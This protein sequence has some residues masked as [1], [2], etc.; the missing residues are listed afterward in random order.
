MKNKNTLVI[1]LLSVVVVLAGVATGW[2]ISGK[3]GSS[4]KVGDASVATPEMVSQD[5]VGTASEEADTAEGA[6]ES[7]GIEGEGTHHLVR[8]GGEQQVV[9][10]T[11]TVVDLESFVGKDVQ[12]WGVTIQAQ[13]APWLMDVE[14][15][16]V[17][18]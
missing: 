18:K 13:S 9:Y 1:V 4:V 3:K 7:G 17:L 2:L 8:P 16:K 12:V 14:K 5:E 11:S 15:V 10:L 6:L